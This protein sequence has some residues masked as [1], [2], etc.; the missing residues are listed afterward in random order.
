VA[1]VPDSEKYSGMDRS[2]KN[3]EGDFHTHFIPTTGLEASKVT[4][5]QGHVIVTIFD[6]P[7]AA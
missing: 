4:L 1:C 2:L 6:Q 7:G 3:E 5:K